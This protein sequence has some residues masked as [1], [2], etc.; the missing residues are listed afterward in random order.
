MKDGENVLPRLANLS[1]SKRALLELLLKQ[2][3]GCTP[4]EQTIARRPNRDLAPLSFAQQRQC[5]IPGS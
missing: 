1:P 3:G 2:N 4:A 5:L